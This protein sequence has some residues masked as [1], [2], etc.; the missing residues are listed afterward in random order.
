MNVMAKEAKAVL[1][2]WLPTI[3]AKGQYYVLWIYYLTHFL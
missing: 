3:K 1:M 2:M